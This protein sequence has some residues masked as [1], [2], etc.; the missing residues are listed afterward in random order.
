MRVGLIIKRTAWDL[1]QEQ[2]NGRVEELLASRDPTVANIVPAHQEHVAT[3]AAVKEALARAGAEVAR[4]R[5]AEFDDRGLDLVVTVG[6]DGTLLRASHSVGPRVP[7]LA[8]NSAPTYSV[9]FFC[10]ANQGTAARAVGA[11]LAGKLR[12]LTLTRMAVRLNGEVVHA[13]VLNDTLFCHQSPAATSRY[14]LEYRGVAEEQKSSGVWI[15]PAA[16]STAAQHSAGGKV[17]P[18]GSRDLQ[19]VVREPYKPRGKPY[20]LTRFV[21]KAG[22]RVL[23]R[24]KSRQM[25]LFSDGPEQT[26]R[27]VLGDVVEFEEAPEPLTVLG[28]STRRQWHR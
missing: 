4:I 23:F 28:I 19:V 16:G 11:A 6:G 22:T 5:T 14:I 2:P 20:R 15:G 10:G 18:L 8:V 13:R 1:Y 12:G 21:I 3:V 24:S 7:I 9:G 26:A 27:A 25:R 17:L